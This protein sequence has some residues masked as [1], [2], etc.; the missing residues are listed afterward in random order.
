MSQVDAQRKGVR[1]LG[2][3]E[4][5]RLGAGP[6]S[7]TL[8]VTSEDSDLF[9]LLDY[10]VPAGF[11]AP[12]TLHHHVSE[13]WAAYVLEGEL[14]FLF[15][16]GPEQAGPGTTVFVHSGEDFAWR[17]DG[18]EPARFL[19]IHAPA[20]FDRFFVDVAEGVAARGGKVT[21]EVMGEI[22]PPLWD[23]YGI[24]PA[25]PQGPDGG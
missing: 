10:R 13:D 8:K 19:A 25:A 5:V 16:D 2:S 12:P 24:E 20:G 7:I 3:D 14:T 17:N 4:G 9:T 15:P 1:V 22:V 23:Q 21:P 11:T 6:V 18:D